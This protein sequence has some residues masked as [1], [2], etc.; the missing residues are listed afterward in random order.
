M[1]GPLKSLCVQNLKSVSS[2]STRSLSTSRTVAQLQQ[3]AAAASYFEEDQLSMQ[4]TAKTII[5]QDINPFV[6]E[7]EASGQY[8]AKQVFKK[9]AEAGLLGVN[10]PVEY[11]GMGLNF[12]FSI[13]LN[14]TLGHIRCGAVPMSIAV[15]TDMATPALARFGSEYVKREF[16]QPS[17]AGEVSLQ[18]SVFHNI[19]TCKVLDDHTCVHL[20]STVQA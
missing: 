20:Q 17:I 3:N 10:K 14:E 18:F 4:K 6:D 15:Q 13:A 5:D 16:L 9:L 19:K 1:R 8:P 12:K 11:G 2:H 7:W